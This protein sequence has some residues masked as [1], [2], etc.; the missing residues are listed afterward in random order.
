MYSD[1]AGEID[2]YLATLRANIHPL[3]TR[4][5]ALEPDRSKLPSLSASFFSE[6]DKLRELADSRFPLDEGRT[7]IASANKPDSGNAR[8]SIYDP[9]D[10]SL[11]PG[12]FGGIDSGQLLF[13]NPTY[14]GSVLKFEFE[15]AG[16]YI[17]ELCMS[18][19]PNT[20]VRLSEMKILKG[21]KGNT[22]YS[23]YFSLRSERAVFSFTVPDNPLYSLALS[24]S[25]S[26][27]KPAFRWGKFTLLTGIPG[28]DA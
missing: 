14:N 5:L 28:Y 13:A 11:S 16:H 12:M 7:S 10:F 9:D 25:S 18:V 15:R 22:K 21:T 8:L 2:S 17:A 23:E 3:K 27:A 26:D 4:L 24:F 1:P 19:A 20:T 6:L